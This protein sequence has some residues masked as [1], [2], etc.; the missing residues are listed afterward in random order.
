MEMRTAQSGHA[1]TV[2]CLKKAKM[3]MTFQ[4]IQAVT[5]SFPNVGGHQEPFQKVTFSPSQKRHFES[6]GFAFVPSK[7]QVASYL[8]HLDV[9]LMYRF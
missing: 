8:V 2:P 5:F 6:P 9:F 3:K 1:V 4:V 7:D